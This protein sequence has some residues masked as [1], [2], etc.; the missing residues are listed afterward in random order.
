MS[1][2]TDVS[3]WFG[4]RQCINRPS[5]PLRILGFCECCTKPQHCSFGYSCITLM[6]GFDPL[7]TV[8]IAM[9]ILFY[10]SMYIITVYMFKINLTCLQMQ[11]WEN[12]SVKAISK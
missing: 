9:F 8:I 7:I 1:F 3:Q 5:F 6:K 2:R 12:M 10:I 4:I 11:G